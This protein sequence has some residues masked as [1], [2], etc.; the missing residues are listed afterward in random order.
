MEKW[1]TFGF[2]GSMCILSS[3]YYGLFTAIAALILLIWAGATQRWLYRWT[4]IGIWLTVVSVLSLTIILGPFLSFQ[5]SLGAEDALVTR[6]PGFVERSLLNHNITDI[7]AFFNPSK[8]PSPNL[9]LLYGE[10]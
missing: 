6:D 5:A 2:F 8:V 4:T 10:D 7:I 3:W 1:A 9:F